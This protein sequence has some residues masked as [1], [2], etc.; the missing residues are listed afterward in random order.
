MKR[1]LLCPLP[2]GSRPLSGLADVNLVWSRKKIVPRVSSK[3]RRSTYSRGGDFARA[4]LG[5]ARHW[6]EARDTVVTGSVA[7]H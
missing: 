3:M 5:F 1:P 4:G 6:R 2:V 7:P